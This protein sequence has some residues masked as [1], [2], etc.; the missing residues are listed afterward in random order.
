MVSCELVG[1]TVSAHLPAALE[2]VFNKAHKRHTPTCAKAKGD[3]IKPCQPGGFGAW[4]ALCTLCAPPVFS[5]SIWMVSYSPQ[6]T[7]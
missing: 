6:V 5:P 1:L 2:L 3:Q 4:Q 7:Q